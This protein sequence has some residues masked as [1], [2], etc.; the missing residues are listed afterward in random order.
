MRI[1]I[2]AG[3]TGGHIFPA[4]AIYDKIME[5]E[6]DSNILYIGTTDRMEKDI[7]PKRG[8]EYIGLE[9]YG[10]NRKNMFKNIKTIYTFIKSI[11][12][13][14]QI[15]K[16]FK[17][18]L[19]IGVGG[20]VTA[21]VIYAAK[22]LNIKTAIHEQN[23]TFGLTNKL[24]LK[25]SDIIFTSLPDTVKY[26][27]EYSDKIIYSGNPCSEVA[28]SK[29]KKN[30]EELG[31]NKS[32]KLIAI[33]TG[34]LG[35]MLVNKQ[36]KEMLPQ[37]KDKDYEVLFVTGKNYYDEFKDIKIKNVKIFPFIDELVS[38]L[39]SVD[40]L[41]TRAGAT[42]LSEIIS[43][44]LPS[45]LIPSPYVTEN[46]QYKNAMDLVNKDAAILLEEKELS[47]LI[48]TIDNI[49]NDEKQLNKIKNNLK[50]F[51]TINSATI[52]YDNLKKIIG[53]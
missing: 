48:D 16:K 43:I 10:F 18:D 51:K 8:I 37:F 35:S 13:S 46:H 30:K 7:V 11:N 22:K 45:I 47:K 24:L 12:K 31:F 9:T 34:S 19:V 29:I 50:Q 40:L 25:Y 23:S 17:P 33:I 3:G 15:I 39:K 38:I 6:P 14:K 27:K 1:I 20:Y 36:I 44:S 32:K 28:I 26:A 5:K 49:I 2:T 42:T 52:I 41:V 4:L 21:P 53:E